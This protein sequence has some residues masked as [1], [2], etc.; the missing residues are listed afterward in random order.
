ME[1]KMV[2][3][4]VPASFVDAVKGFAD[5]REMKTSDAYRAILWVGWRDLTEPDANRRW[6]VERAHEL[7]NLRNA[8]MDAEVL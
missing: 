8:M 2:T 5:G 4:Q 7:A 1:K 6:T 3:V